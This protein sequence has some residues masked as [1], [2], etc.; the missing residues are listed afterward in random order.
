MPRAGCGAARRARPLFVAAVVAVA[1]PT[2]CTAGSGDP[3]GPSGAAAIRFVD[4]AGVSGIPVQ[5]TRSWG[6]TWAD[7]VGDDG[8]PDLF[9]NRHGRYPWLLANNE[10]RFELMQ[11]DFYAGFFDRHGCVWGEATG[12]GLIDLYCPQGADEGVGEGPNQLQAQTP[13][14]FA[15]IAARVGVDDPG[16]RGRSANWMDAD[17]DNDLDLF[18]GN[19]LRPEHTNLFFTNT[20]EGFRPADVGLNDTLRTVNSTWADWDVDGDPDLLVLQYP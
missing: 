1:G 20:G 16:G 13:S 10:G 2:G 5:D 4:A 9:V 8:W 6:S 19:K 12:D 15:D 18:V 14:G 3:V 11:E 7:F 17:G